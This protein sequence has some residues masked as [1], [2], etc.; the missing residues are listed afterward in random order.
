VKIIIENDIL[1]LS[2]PTHALM[3]IYIEIFFNFYKTIIKVIISGKHKICYNYLIE[4]I[5]LMIALGSLILE[6][7]FGSS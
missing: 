5:L 7:N 4:Y 1:T 3:L 6:S 2:L